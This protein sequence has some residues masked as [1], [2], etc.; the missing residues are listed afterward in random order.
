MDDGKFPAT[1]SCGNSLCRGSTDTG[2]FLRWKGSPASSH[3]QNPPSKSIR[4]TEMQHCMT[5]FFHPRMD[6]YIVV[7]N[8]LTASDFIF[9]ISFRT[10]P[11]I[12]LCEFKRFAGMNKILNTGKRPPKISKLRTTLTHDILAPDTARLKPVCLFSLP[13]DIPLMS[14]L[15]FLR[16]SECKQ[17]KKGRY[18]KRRGGP[19]KMLLMLWSKIAIQWR[20]SILR[21][22]KTEGG[23]HW[24]M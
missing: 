1:T 8:T 20:W 15:N 11:G 10:C 23:T 14:G 21:V 9:S 4:T 3:Y 2:H 17:T 19:K 24:V 6:E 12:P 5:F 22:Q 13:S 7:W 16:I 18:S